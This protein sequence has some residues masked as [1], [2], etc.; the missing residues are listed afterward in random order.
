MALVS[1]A[2]FGSFFFN[3]LF[4][5]HPNVFLIGIAHGVLSIVALPLL[6][7]T[8]VMATGCIGPPELAALTERIAR[9]WR[10]GDHLGICSRVFFESQLHAP[11]TREI[12]RV[13]RGKRDPFAIQDALSR[14]L[15]SEQRVFCLITERELLRYRT[16]EIDLNTKLLQD[17]Y[18][19]RRWNNMP[20]L[21]SNDG[22]IGLF[23][24]RVLLLS[25]KAAPQ[26]AP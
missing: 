8:G 6:I 2:L 25:N 4:F 1:L 5:R 18:I 16:E 17:G 13:L 22:L 21:Q 20:H 7:G 12:E 14:Y 23:R 9:E 26:N 11:F 10:D 24:D 15:A 19:G 3:W